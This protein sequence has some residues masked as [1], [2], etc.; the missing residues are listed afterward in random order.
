MTPGEVMPPMTELYHYVVVGG[1]MTG[2]YL[3][4]LLAEK[5]NR[6][7]LM[8]GDSH[9]GGLA[10]EWDL[11][12]YRASQFY[13]VILSGD[14]DH[15]ALLEELDLREKLQWV[16]AR[17]GFY[18]DGALYSI[19]SISEFLH[20]PPLGFR[21]KVR[22]LFTIASAMWDRNDDD[23]ERLRAV[24]WLTKVSGRNVTEK[25]WLPLLRAKFGDLH[26]NVS[27]AYLIAILRRMGRARNTASKSELFGYLTG[28]YRA[29]IDSFAQRL[30]SLGVA[31][32]PGHR[33]DS[34]ERVG[35]E[36]HLL[37]RQGGILKADR[38]IVTVPPPLVPDLCR[39][40]SEEEQSILRGIRYNGIICAS[41]LIEK[42]LG[43][44]Y[45]TN[46]ADEN[47]P[48]TGV[49]NMS[50][51]APSSTWGGYTLIYLPRYTSDED[52]LLNC[53]DDEIRSLFVPALEK[54]FRGV[55]SGDIHCFQ[56]ARAAHV[57]P[58]ITPE[59]RSQIPPPL[60]T[61]PGLFLINS[62]QITDGTHNINEVI[63]N[64]KNMLPILT[65]ADRK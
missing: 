36:F 33:V 50:A 48:Y 11:C 18:I 35:N 9:L 30:A 38:V 26:H 45:I 60:T 47:V 20:F 53:A 55:I 23:K 61:I 28:G 32:L 62:A 46:I 29:V 43:N 40:L 6:V 64:A 15:L 56:V 2:M 1:G 63:R 10:D 39:G 24:D 27:A 31:L 25:I 12:S 58:V 14:T 41:L 44:Y 3:S 19:S 22:L 4:R 51:L 42:D 54:M 52:P 21:D 17:T 49:I 59:F 5:G 7:T 8:E 13:H 57:F 34:I 65:E 16:K 37:S